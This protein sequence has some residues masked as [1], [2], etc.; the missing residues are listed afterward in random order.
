LLADSIHALATAG[1]SFDSL[2]LQF[3]NDMSS[4]QKGG[5]IEDVQVGKF[6]PLFE[7]QVMRLKKDGEIAP[8]LLTD[9]GFHII[10]RISNQPIEES[11]SNAAPALKELIL[12]DDR[13]S[14]AADAFIKKNIGQ[15]G[16]TATMANKE[17]Y[18]AKRLEQFNPAYATQIKDFKDGNLLFEI[19][20]K[21]V[22][23]KASRDLEGLKKF[24]AGRSAQYTWKLSVFAVTITAQNKQTA[25]AIR[26]AFEKER[27]VEQIKKMYSEVSFV[28]SGR[29]EAGEL[30][31][32][33]AENAKAGFVTPIYTNNSDESA[34]FIIVVN[35]FK[36][37]S[38][39]TFEEAR[40][41]VINDYQQ[42]L[43][44]GWMASLKKKYPVVLNT[45]TWKNLA[46]G[47]H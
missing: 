40:G 23:G 3:S 26:E 20:D 28:D 42:Y 29:Y 1:V 43:E 39:K 13:K 16:L 37:P 41:T 11:L 8:V 44:D 7:E 30:L 47:M 14:I 46:A 2:V 45:Q 18:I 6:D 33:G 22:W 31:G 17:D 25:L 27:S 21:K 38:T 24:H 36:D 19:M 35:V 15:H 4:A 9:L 32:V 10:K 34:S 5:I 12:Q